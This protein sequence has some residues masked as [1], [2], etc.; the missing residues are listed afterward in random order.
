[1]SEGAATCPGCGEAVDPLRA[2]QVAILGGRFH[3]FCDA[4]C[5]ARYLD[6]GAAAAWTQAAT[7]E[8]PRVE[9]SS[10][11]AA[12]PA[13]ASLAEGDRGGRGTPATATPATPP[14]RFDVAAP[15]IR[16]ADPSEEGGVE[17]GARPD[18]A[19]EDESPLS[20][21]LDRVARTEDARSR[22]ARLPATHRAVL[23]AAVALGLLS[24]LAAIGGD[25][26][27]RIRV[28]G[29]ILAA[30]C[31]VAAMLTRPRA[32]YELHPALVVWPH[33]LAACV[34]VWA[35]SAGDPSTLAFA[36][37]TGLSCACFA[38]TVLFLERAVERNAR[39]TE[40]IRAALPAEVK[41]RIGEQIV[42]TPVA[43][44]KPGQ[45]VVVDAGDVLGVDGV[46][47][48]GEVVVLP[49]PFAR[50]AVR[51]RE[52]DSLVAGA[53]IESGRALVVA[54]FGARE[55]AYERAL[56][57]PLVRAELS[58]PVVL[59][60]RLLFG[61]ALFG[62]GILAAA[63]VFASNGSVRDMLMTA[64]AAAVA[65]SAPGVLG[66][67]AHTQGRGHLLALSRGILYRDARSF[68]AASRADLAVLCARGT[69]LL[70]EPEIVAIDGLT[71]DANRVLALAAG[72]ETGST[73]PFAAAI[74]RA[75]RIR[76]QVAEAT[77]SVHAHAGLGVA[78]LAP[79]GERI[80][81]GSRAFLLQEK[82]SV[83]VAETRTSELE[84]QG[85]SVLLVA[86]GEK[87]VGLVALQ[88]GLRPGARAAIERL[89]QARIEPVLLSGEARDTCETIGRALG[90]DHVRPEV[91]R[92]DRGAEVRALAESGHLVAV[93]GQPATDD[94]A[95]GAADLSVALGAAG[96]TPGEWSVATC[97][98]DVRNAAYALTLARR[99][100][101]L[102]VRV[103]LVGVAPGAAMTLALVFG[104]APLWAAA[105]AG[106]VATIASVAV[107][108]DRADGG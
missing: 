37:L 88:D 70:G 57:N 55:R 103:L 51:R 35:A 8:P 61:R 93:L 53:R 11:P 74:E 6:V 21:E 91:L 75:A 95:L 84:A 3:Y 42:V 34:T 65:F 30:A 102:G 50:T 20:L 81:V 62:V 17:S 99:T 67:V 87:L 28:P 58:A 82:I 76:G 72:A 31:L 4:A 22:G 13:R 39:G 100:R 83:A 105:G 78:A 40:A 94:G 43:D 86:F 63:A 66:A 15:S 68:D 45:H 97:D 47:V 54:T 36:G 38:G 14:P 2:G 23:V 101:D 25:V 73:H 106:L 107:M 52:G 96:A 48:E 60:S 56:V 18:P 108:R 5:K 49:H 10:A 1:M 41:T 59:F 104:L 19:V 24:F 77:R 71:T 46:L 7:A 44:V 90:I 29:G 33:V 64:A 79:S 26:S 89:V 27:S 80:V 12:P 92:E 85:R 16:H 32:R 98:D 69:V 9:P